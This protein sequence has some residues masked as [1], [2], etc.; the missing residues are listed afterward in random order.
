MTSYDFLWHQLLS[1][2]DICKGKIL[3]EPKLPQLDGGFYK[4]FTAVDS[5]ENL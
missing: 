2:K 1:V 3:N 4:W 5:K